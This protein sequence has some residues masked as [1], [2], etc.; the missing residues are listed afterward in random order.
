MVGCNAILGFNAVV[1]CCAK[2]GCNAC[3]IVLHQAFYTLLKLVDV[4][5]S[6]VITCCIVVHQDF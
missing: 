4:S 5:R 6:L 1:G 2:V 3:F